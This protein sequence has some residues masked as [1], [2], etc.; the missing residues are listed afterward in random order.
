MKNLYPASGGEKA[1][2]NLFGRFRTVI[3]SV[4]GYEGSIA[5]YSNYPFRNNYSKS[6]NLSVS[7]GVY[8][9]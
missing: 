4:L 5:W 2:E 8:I 3:S 1:H 9:E 6:C 7:A